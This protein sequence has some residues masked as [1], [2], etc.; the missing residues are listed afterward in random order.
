M[1][2]NSLKNLAFVF[3]IMCYFH[4]FAQQTLYSRAP[5]SPVINFVTSNSSIDE[6]KTKGSPYLD[7]NFVQ[8]KVVRKGKTQL[9][10]NMRFNAYTN[11]VEIQDG[12]LKQGYASLY[13]RREFQAVIG[14]KTYS[15]NV[16]KDKDGSLKSSYFVELNKGNLKL[17]FKPEVILRPARRPNTSY[18][19]YV[20]PTYIWNSSYYIFD[21]TK[22][23]EE[24]YAV[25]IGLSKNNILKYTGNKKD[26][27]KQFVKDSN[28]NLRRED[29]VIS[30]LDYYNSINE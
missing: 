30:L 2:K 20:P 9:V 23:T 22:P 10:A 8:G 4:S 21:T 28:L 25:E 27:M 14:G 11:E 26:V 29:D 3:G 24:N 17:L 16:Y 13:K 15:I 19:R 5:D 18:G 7:K 1:K 12:T 6:A